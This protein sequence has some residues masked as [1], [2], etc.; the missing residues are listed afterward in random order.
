MLF[1]MF[2]SSLQVTNYIMCSS[3]VVG[4]GTGVFSESYAPN[5]WTFWISNE[6]IY[7]SKGPLVMFNGHMKCQQKKIF[8]GKA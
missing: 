4:V 1:E 3:H 6:L 2:G 7:C 5:K 8:K